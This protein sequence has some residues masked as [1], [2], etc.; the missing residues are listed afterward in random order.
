MRQ[1]DVRSAEFDVDF[2]AWVAPFVMG[3]INTRIV[4]RT[5]AL[6]EQAYG[7]DFTYD[8]AICTGRGLR[9]LRCHRHG[10]GR[11]RLLARGCHPT[12]ARGT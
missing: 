9:A 6:S 1:P 12:G 3:G 2:A 7:A 5:N 10:R 8:E 11:L 4:Q